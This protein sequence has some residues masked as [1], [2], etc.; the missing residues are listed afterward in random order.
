MKVRQTIFYLLIGGM[1]IFS[2]IL[3]GKPVPEDSASLLYP[4]VDHQLE[5]LA[6]ITDSYAVTLPAFN[7]PLPVYHFLATTYYF[8]R[9]PTFF[10]C[11]SSFFISAFLRNV[12]YVF[13]SIHAP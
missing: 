12:I 8:D 5:K 1:L 6:I 2:N 13:I 4:S 9:Y 3:Y 10:C 11:K 7:I